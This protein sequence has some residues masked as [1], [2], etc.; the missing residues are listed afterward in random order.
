MIFESRHTRSVITGIAAPVDEPT[1]L[2]E[3]RQLDTLLMCCIYVV[4]KAQ[5]GR[6]PTPASTPVTPGAAG[7]SYSMSGVRPIQVDRYI[8]IPVFILFYTYGYRR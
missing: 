1:K 2:V 5:A 7:P 8:S 4:E 3:G 6:S